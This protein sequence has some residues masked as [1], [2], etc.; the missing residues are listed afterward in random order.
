MAITTIDGKCIGS[1]VIGDY[2]ILFTTSSSFDRIYKVSKPTNNSSNVIRLFRGHLNFNELNK[3]QT[4]PFYEN[5]N[6]QKVY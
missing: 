3:I 4:L 6:I 1:C 2:L 5:E